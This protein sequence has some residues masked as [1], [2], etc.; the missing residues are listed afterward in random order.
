[1]YFVEWN[2]QSGTFQLKRFREMHLYF[3][4]LFSNNNKNRSQ[5]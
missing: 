2:E 3:A 4:Y 1:M 5:I